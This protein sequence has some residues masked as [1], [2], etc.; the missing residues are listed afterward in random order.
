MPDVTDRETLLQLALMTYNAYLPGPGHADWQSFG[1][2]GKI[3]SNTS[4]PFGWDTGD[5]LR[6]HIFENVDKSIVVVS[7]KGTSAG[8]FGY[9][10]GTARN[11]Q[12]NVSSQLAV[13]HSVRSNYVGQS[14]L[15]LLLCP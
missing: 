6:G 12:I 13:G 7:I 9:G 8:F 2:D 3:W 14:S 1:D 15:F 10:G 5:G 4:L 11:D